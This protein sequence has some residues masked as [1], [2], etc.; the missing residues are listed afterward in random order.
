MVDVA[1][2]FSE[3]NIKIRGNIFRVEFEKQEKNIPSVISANL[4]LTMYWI[5]KIK[6]KW[7][8]LGQKVTDLKQS[9]EFTRNVLEEKV[10]KLGEPVQWTTRVLSRSIFTI[11]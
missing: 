8:K 10:K 9:L 11:S 1:T 7:R 6:M 5:K 2:L 3:E 4:K